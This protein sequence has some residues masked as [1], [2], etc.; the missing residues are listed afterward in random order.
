MLTYLVTLTIIVDRA[1]YEPHL[2]DHLAYLAQLKAAGHL[3]LSGPATDRRG[4]FV[5]LQ[6]DSLA[7][8]RDLVEE[9]PLVARGLDSYEIREWRI[10]EGQ[11]QQIVP[12]W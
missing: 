11:P 2:P 12:S 10:T 7:A 6:A 8:A 5:L 9:D 3:L 1:I 4:G